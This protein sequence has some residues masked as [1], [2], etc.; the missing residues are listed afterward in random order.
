MARNMHGV[1]ETHYMVRHIASESGASAGFVA[2]MV[3][4]Y[5]DGPLNNGGWELD[6]RDGTVGGAIIRNAMVAAFAYNEQDDDDDWDNTRKLREWA[7]HVAQVGI[8]EYE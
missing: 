2:A 3:E 6:G 4:Y 7:Y 1:D 5:S 8:K